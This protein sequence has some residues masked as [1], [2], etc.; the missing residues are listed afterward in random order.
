[1]S[2]INDK[3]KTSRKVKDMNRQVRKVQ[4]QTVNNHMKRYSNKTKTY[5]TKTKDTQT[6]SS[7][8][9]KVKMRSH[10]ILTRLENLKKNFSI[11]NSCTENENVK[12][13][14]LYRKG[15]NLLN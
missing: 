1:M 5:Q 7:E 14:N 9:N 2:L 10:F 12:Y 6:P 8:G 3:K 4:T 13:Y 15:H 11:Y